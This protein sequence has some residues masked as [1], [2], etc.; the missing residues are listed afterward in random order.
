MN[1]FAEVT[2]PHV[3]YWDDEGNEINALSVRA[4]GGQVQIGDTAPAP[5]LDVDADA[6]RIIIEDMN[7][8][9]T[10]ASVVRALQKRVALWTDAQVSERL[11]CDIRMVPFMREAGVGWTVDVVQKLAQHNHIS[12]SQMLAGTWDDK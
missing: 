6:R 11:E 3:R 4:D 9:R 5:L 12:I 10:G 7:R 1:S 8:N 2:T